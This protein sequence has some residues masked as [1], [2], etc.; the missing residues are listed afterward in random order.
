MDYHTLSIED[1]YA[2][3]AEYARRMGKLSDHVKRLKAAKNETNFLASEGLTFLK[4]G[5]VVQCGNSIL[6]TGIKQSLFLYIIWTGKNHSATFNEIETKIWKSKIVDD[7]TFRSFVSKLQKKIKDQ[8]FP[9]ILEKFCNSQ[10]NTHEGFT[11][12]VSFRGNK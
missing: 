5:R 11:I 4:N 10:T 12:R 7:R 3:M 8:N 6:E 2:L 9:I 1:S